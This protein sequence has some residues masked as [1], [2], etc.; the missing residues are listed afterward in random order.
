M[1]VI[2]LPVGSFK[3]VA[4]RGAL[5]RGV[6]MS[7]P[8]RVSVKAMSNRR[9]APA[10]CAGCAAAIEFGTVFHRNQAY[11]SVECSLGGGLP[12]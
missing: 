5:R 3:E 1:S 9:L 2:Q 7:A 12:A 8:S 10:Y 11:C 4:E 6:S